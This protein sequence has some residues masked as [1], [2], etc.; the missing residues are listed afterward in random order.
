M[1]PRN[2]QLD[3]VDLRLIR[4]LEQDGRATN[5]AL[6]RAV[7]LTEGAVRRRVSNLVSRGALRI[8]G[9]TSADVYGLD[10][11]AMVCLQVALS[12]VANVV[13]Q[14]VEMDEF[15]FVYETVGRFNV[16]A[17]GF[18]R[19]NDDFHSFIGRNLASLPGIS[20]METQLILVTNKRN[21]AIARPL[22]GS[23]GNR[24]GGGQAR[25]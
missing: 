24:S 9:V 21:Y 22:T 11:H 25:G 13:G 19:D 2:V 3:P 20:H 6:G 8:V 10:L 1:K 18:F 4:L 14:L 7:G 17:V 16:I 12:E 15:S 5:A 23:A